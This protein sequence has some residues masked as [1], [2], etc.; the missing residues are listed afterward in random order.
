MKILPI[1]CLTDWQQ[2]KYMMQET[3]LFRKL[4]R[5]LCIPVQ[6]TGGLI[7]LLHI[8]RLVDLK[9]G[10]LIFNVIVIWIMVIF[11][12]VTL[13]Y[14]VLKRFIGFLESLKLPI[15]RKFGR[16]LHVKV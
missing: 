9:I 10:T 8:N 5:F 3:G 6:D 12:F 13:Y 16:D 7:F 4:I 15:L 14:N 11:L 1:L 2:I